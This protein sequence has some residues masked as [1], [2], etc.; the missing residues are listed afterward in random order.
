MWY[1]LLSSTGYN[2]ASYLGIQWGGA[3]GD[4]PLPNDWDGDLKADPVIWRP[5]GNTWYA[6]RSS[7]GYATSQSVVLGTTGAVPVRVK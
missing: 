5:D 3:A 7:A 6:L 1:V 2:V 4:V